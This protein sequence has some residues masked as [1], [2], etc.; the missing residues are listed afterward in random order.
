[1]TV[2]FSS[3]R[4]SPKVP[5]SCLQLSCAGRGLTEVHCVSC[6]VYVPEILISEFIYYF[7]VPIVLKFVSLKFLDPSV[8]VQ[9]CIEFA[10]PLLLILKSKMYLSYVLQLIP[11]S[12]YSL[13]MASR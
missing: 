13:R 5:Y 1:L 12:R 7:H 2:Y 11:T 6:V 8:P 4:V 3:V 9:A 10:S